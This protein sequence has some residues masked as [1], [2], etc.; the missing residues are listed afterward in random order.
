MLQTLISVFYREEVQLAIVF[1]ILFI[2]ICLLWFRWKHR[3]WI[4]QP[5]FH[6]Y[7]L[8]YWLYPP[9]I[10]M[11]T[12]PKLDE[13][14]DPMIRFADFNSLE[15]Y[16]VDNMIDLLKVHYLQKEDIKYQPSRNSVIPYFEGHNYP[17]YISFSYKKK[18]VLDFRN[19]QILQKTKPICVM[20]S[21][22]MELEYQYKNKRES[23]ILYYADYLCTR[24]DYRKKGRTQ[25]N[26]FTHVVHYR[27]Q[28]PKN[29][30]HFFKREGKQSVYI[31]LVIYLSYG[32][33]LKRWMKPKPFSPFIKCTWV[34]SKNIHI[35][36]NFLHD[37]KNRFT[38]SIIPE[39]GNIQS[40]IKTQNYFCFLLMHNDNP[41][42]CYFFRNSFTYYADYAK[43]SDVPNSKLRDKM[44]RYGNSIELFATING[45]ENTR[46]NN[47]LFIQGFYHSVN[48]IL[49]KKSFQHRVLVIENISNNN[50]ILKNVMVKYRTIFKVETGYYYY[51]FAL[52]PEE[53]KNVLIIT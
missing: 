13:Y 35:L 40:L 16:E 19:K 43:S 8:Q 9:G 32:F 39:M 36:Q 22:P 37:N 1:L 46:E 29:M 34:T 20:T 26:I 31:P 50:R 52:L 47:N 48:E 45:L 7:K 24:R 4:K 3:F 14:Y 42:C 28:T 23:L 49:L 33:S 25:E 41:I 10:I 30:V 44:L 6:A 12:L 27:K 21:R 5:V 15:Q 38:T 18:P 53:S 51:N 2:V 11:R 17:S